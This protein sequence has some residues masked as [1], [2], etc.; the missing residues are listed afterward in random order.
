M[1]TVEWCSS[2]YWKWIVKY[3]VNFYQLSFC[4]YCNRSWICCVLRVENEH[5]KIELE[6]QLTKFKCQLEKYEFTIAENI[7][8]CIYKYSQ[9]K[10]TKFSAHTMWMCDCYHR[11]NWTTN[12]ENWTISKLNPKISTTRCIEVQKWRVL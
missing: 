8:L 5:L 3:K 10:K 1:L 2:E 9:F 12:V 4:I 11:P 7:N 6:T